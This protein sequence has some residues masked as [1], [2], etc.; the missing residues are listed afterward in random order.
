METMLESSI[1]KVSIIEIPLSV[2]SPVPIADPFDKLDAFTSDD[3]IN[4][5]PI[6]ERPDSTA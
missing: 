3:K 2:A 5:E 1:I 4:S 6:L